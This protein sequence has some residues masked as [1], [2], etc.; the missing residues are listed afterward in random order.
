MTKGYIVIDKS[1]DD[2][3]ENAGIVTDEEGNNKVFDTFEE[4]EEE[5]K[6]CQSAMIVGTDDIPEHTPSLMLDI[7]VFLQGY[8]ILGTEN[9][10]EAQNLV[11][12]ITI[13]QKDL[14]ERN[15]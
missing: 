6:E 1:T 13:W 9:R 7:K 12:R 2:S 10:E 15:S 3:W 14:K 4:A 11:D 5:A 8:A